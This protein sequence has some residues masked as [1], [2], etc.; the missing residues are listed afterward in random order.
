[1][2]LRATLGCKLG[3]QLRPK[4]DFRN[5]LLHCVP[6]RLLLGFCCLPKAVYFRLQCPTLGTLLQVRPC[7]QFL[8]SL[9]Q[10]IAVL[11]ACGTVAVA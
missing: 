7:T 10:T 6:V 1:M 4:L 5:V 9:P 11:Q 3:L 2:L 8:A